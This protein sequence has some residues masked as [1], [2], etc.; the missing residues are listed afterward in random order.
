MR[1]SENRQRLAVAAARGGALR[2]ELARQLTVL[3][4]TEDAVWEVQKAQEELVGAP[5]DVQ[6]ELARVLALVDAP[7]SAPPDGPADSE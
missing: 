1:L 7:P 2:L 6:A 5:A 3:G 4:R